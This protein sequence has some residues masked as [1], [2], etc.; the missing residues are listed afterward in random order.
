M[1]ELPDFTKSYVRQHG[2]EQR[3]RSTDRACLLARDA[4]PG[5]AALWNI[6]GEPITHIKNVHI[7]QDED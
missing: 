3:P 4:H 5:Q 7:Q 6:L 1:A 2:A